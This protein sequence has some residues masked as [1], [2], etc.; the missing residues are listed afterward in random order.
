[1]TGW[2][3]FRVFVAVKLI[4]LTG[5]GLTVRRSVYDAARTLEAGPVPWL[6]AQRKLRDE[7]FMGTRA[8]VRFWRDV[9]MYMEYRS[10]FYGRED[11]AKVTI[12][13]D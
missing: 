1:M 6:Q 5:R 4:N 7:R 8:G 10:T 13:E 9:M 12:I 3:A 2:S 11:K